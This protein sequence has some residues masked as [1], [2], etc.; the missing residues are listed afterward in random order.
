MGYHSLN[1]LEELSFTGYKMNVI[2]EALFRDLNNLF[3][4]TIIP[5]E[6]FKD[7]LNIVRLHLN[8]NKKSEIQESKHSV[9]LTTLTIFSLI[10][11]K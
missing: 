6:V 5:E 4:I 1:S 8:Y 11:T 10:I 2:S 7:L 3:I 9:V